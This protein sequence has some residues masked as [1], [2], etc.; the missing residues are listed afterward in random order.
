M[1]LKGEQTV[2][3]LTTSKQTKTEYIAPFPLWLVVRKR[4]LGNGSI[5]IEPAWVGCSDHKGPIIFASRMHAEIYAKMRN[6]YHADDD[7]NN[8]KCIPLH[9]FDL[10]EHARVLDGKVN[11]MMAFGFSMNDEQSLIVA[12]GA[13]RLRLVPLP[14]TVPADT[15]QITFSFNEWVFEFM[16]EEWA[17]IGATDF[18]AE[19][20]T[21]D[22]M[23]ATT[24]RHAAQIAIAS[25]NVTCDSKDSSEWGVYCAASERWLSGDDTPYVNRNVH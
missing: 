17:A 3:N 13:P 20:E 10:L 8:W 16:R 24:F 4:F 7:S 9:E 5:F 15:D 2:G 12:S 21:V 14:F 11:C 22:D 6:T 25:A 18:E 1:L 23:D 19:L